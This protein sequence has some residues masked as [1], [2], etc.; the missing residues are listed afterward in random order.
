MKKLTIDEMHIIAETR[1]GRCLSKTYIN[2]RTKLLWE[3]EN[4]HRWEAIPGSVK[5]GR[6]CLECAGLKKHTIE[7]MKKL[8]EGRGGK[9]LSKV[10][11]NNRTKLHWECA[12]K[13]RWEATPKDII[14]GSWCRICGIK[15]ASEER[16][17]TIEQMHQLAKG[18]GGKCHSTKYINNRTK[19]LWECAYGH[20]W[21]TTPD[22]AKQG[23]WCPICGRENAAKKHRLTIGE[24]QQIAESHNGKCLSRIYTNKRTKL[25]WECS[26]G[27]QWKAIPD[28]IKRGSWCPICARKK[29]KRAY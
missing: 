9:C 5:K 18:R 2:S 3:C 21:K 8:A 4:G 19:L 28:N 22:S 29:R 12:K 24:M 27:H 16:S 10:Y 17:L 14:K 23:K 15:S 20:Q 11:V 7:M 13:H 1:N 25:L 6:W 26:E